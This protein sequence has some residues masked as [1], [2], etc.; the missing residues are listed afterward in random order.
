MKHQGFT[1]L[2]LLMVI[3]IIGILAAIAVPSYS[4]YV[5]KSRRADAMTALTALQIKM[6]KFRGSCIY[7]PKNTGNGD[8]C[9]ASSAVSTIEFPGTSNDNHYT[10][11]IPVATANTYTLK[12]V[13]VGDQANDTD[14]PEMTITVTNSKPKGVKAP[15][16]CW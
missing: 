12:A 4:G 10:I 5:K 3:A 9:G 8:V 11:T 7:Y 1:L 16:K 15:E 6:E 2:E 14:C 13:P